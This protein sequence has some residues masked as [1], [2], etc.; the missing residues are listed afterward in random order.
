MQFLFDYYDIEMLLS[1]G[2]QLQVRRLLSN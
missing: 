2:R 1:Q